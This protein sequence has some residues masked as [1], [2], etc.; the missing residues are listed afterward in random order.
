[1]QHDVDKR[2]RLMG[3]PGVPGLI[4]TECGFLIWRGTL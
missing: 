3:S 4:R 1:M 2:F